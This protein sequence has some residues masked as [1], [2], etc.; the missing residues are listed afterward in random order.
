MTTVQSTAAPA[1][2]PVWVRV[3][4][5]NHARGAFLTGYVPGLTVTEVF[6]YTTS[7]KAG[8]SDHEVAEEAFELFNIG[9][10]PEFGTPDRR[11]VDYRARG[12]RSLS[13]GDVLAIDGRFFS[14][15]S[16]GWH[17][18]TVPPP[19]DQ[20]TAPGTTPLYPSAQ[21]PPPAEPGGGKG[22]E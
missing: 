9:D 22:T 14:C 8:T 7:P 2:T 16:N 12:N 4:H 6:T 19:I 5:N 17:A 13:V 18:L 3:F 11:A 1:G 20:V 15:D 10:D 21:P